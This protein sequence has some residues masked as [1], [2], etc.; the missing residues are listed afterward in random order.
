[1][2]FLPLWEKP[3][4]KWTCS[5]RGQRRFFPP[6]W[7]FMAKRAESGTLQARLSR[8]G[9]NH[10]FFPC[11]VFFFFTPCMAKPEP[12]CRT[13]VP[14]CPHSVLGRGQARRAAC[15][16]CASV[17]QATPMYFFPPHGFFPPFLVE[18]CSRAEPQ[19]R[20][21]ALFFPRSMLGHS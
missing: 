18:T 17:K 8:E 20:R 3:V 10:V 4:A 1:M 2:G 5:T 13:T 21:T 6:P 12:R 15:S 16:W 14:V 7:Q 19:C 9:Y 11:V